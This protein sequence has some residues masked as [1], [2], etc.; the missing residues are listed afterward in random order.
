MMTTEDAVNVVESLFHKQIEAGLFCDANTPTSGDSTARTQ[1]HVFLTEEAKRT[2]FLR[3][4][5]QRVF[6]PR[7]RTLVGSPPFTFLRPADNGLLRAGGIAKN[8]V[9][10]AVANTTHGVMSQTS[11]HFVDMYERKYRVMSSIPPSTTIPFISITTQSTSIVNVSLKRVTRRH[12]MDST[13]SQ[14]TRL[15]VAG[16]FITLT[17]TSA[18]RN[19]ACETTIKVC[20]VVPRSNFACEILC[21]TI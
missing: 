21:M 6:W 12:T 1:F 14:I 5:R 2:L 17:P 19:F 11:S 13:R 3:L 9:N 8:R 16:D 7:I 10:M 20:R 15:P 18:T 4:C